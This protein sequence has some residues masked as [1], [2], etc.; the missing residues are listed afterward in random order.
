[1]NSKPTHT[2]AGSER[3]LETPV[4][5]DRAVADATVEETPTEEVT[6]PTE[7]QL[8]RIELPEPDA[9]NITVLTHKLPNKPILPWNRYDSPWEEAEAEP[10]EEPEPAADEASEADPQVNLPTEEQASAKTQRELEEVD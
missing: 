10:K 6:A 9:E 4:E 1:M 2:H 3:N 5:S 8:D 7:T